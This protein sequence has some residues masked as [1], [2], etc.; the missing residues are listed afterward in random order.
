MRGR[1]AIGVVAVAL[2]L[3]PG[4]GDAAGEGGNP[5]AVADADTAADTLTDPD[6][7]TATA[8]DTDTAADTGPPALPGTWRALPPVLGGPVQEDAVVAHDGSV[9]V[10]GGFT[11]GF[12][13]V[14]T[15]RA[16]D[17][18]A[19]TW[20][21]GPDLPRPLHH[22]N[23][24]AVDGRLLVL[25]ALEGFGFSAVAVAY[26]LEPDEGGFSALTP[27]PEARRRGASGVAVV[28]TDAWVVAGFRGRAVAEVDVYHAATD[29]WEAG[30]ALPA[31]R[32]HGVAAAVDGV[33]YWLGGRDTAIDAVSAD[34]WALTP[35]DGAWVTRAP[36]P[37][38]RGGTAAAVVGGRV[39]VLGG[40]G[41]PT[42]ATG[43]FADVEVYDPAT[44]TWSRLAPMPTPRHGTGAAA[45]GG[46]VYVPG[47]ADHESFGW[48]DT[49]EALTP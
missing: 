11:T 39:V 2:A 18:T 26:R 19:G 1:G 21:A 7:A 32:D 43:V 15:T 17:A 42:N 10:L 28:G 38:P 44:D 8:A 4:C 47:G 20:R 46:V 41:D 23:A 16:Y 49:F 48:V 6:T 25:G 24:A 34:V 35:G 29:T 40:E 9:W 36:M 22:V 13:V 37:T 5:D 14:A 30:P 45:L 12:A 33:V 27:L 3:A 31:P